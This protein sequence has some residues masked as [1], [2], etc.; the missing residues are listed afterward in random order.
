MHE[1]AGKDVL[2]G[3]RGVD[4]HVVDLRLLAGFPDA[5]DKIFEF[6]EIVLPD[7]GGLGDDL[8][9]TLEPHEPPHPVEGEFDFVAIQ[10]VKQDHIVAAKSEV[11]N[12]GDEFVGVVKKVREEDD[13]PT[14]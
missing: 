10:N 14:S 3:I 1:I 8:A 4:E 5:A 11:V 2:D 6:F 9:F 7:P 13:E 12:P